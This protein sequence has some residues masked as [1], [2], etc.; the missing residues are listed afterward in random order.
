MRGP[1]SVG[2]W[3]VLPA[4]LLVAGALGSGVAPIR[5]RARLLRAQLE[6]TGIQPTDGGTVITVVTSAGLAGSP[7]VSVDGTTRTR[8]VR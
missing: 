3:A 8:N 5:L 1:R 4:I 2:R 6:V 7:T